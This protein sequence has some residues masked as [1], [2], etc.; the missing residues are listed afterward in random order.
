[1]IILLS[2]MV[3]YSENTGL[4]HL[5]PKPAGWSANG[6]MSLY[7]QANLYEYIDG[8]ADNFLAYEPVSII[9]A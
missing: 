5:L 7:D 4:D 1:M 9:E 6:S 3:I 8:A 2:P